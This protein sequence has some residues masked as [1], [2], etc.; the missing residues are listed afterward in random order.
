METKNNTYSQLKWSLNDL[1][2]EN[3]NQAIEKMFSTIGEEV[4]KFEKF[5]SSLNKDLSPDDFLIIVKSLEQIHY[6]INKLYAYAELKFSENTQDQA[7]LSL[8]SRIEQTVSRDIQQGYILH[9][10]VER[11]TGGYC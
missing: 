6:K 10:M 2:P 9:S 3:D 11:S 8:L 7:A 4:S 1:F 5:R